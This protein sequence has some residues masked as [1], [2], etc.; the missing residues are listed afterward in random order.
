MKD[1]KVTDN[2]NQTL[3]PTNIGA[4]SYFKRIQKYVSNEKGNLRRI[5]EEKK[6]T[7]LEVYR[8]PFSTKVI[9]NLIRTEKELQKKI[10]KIQENEK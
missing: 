1:E 7:S 10:K 9:K 6:N 8:D 3:L 5:K 2:I 4:R